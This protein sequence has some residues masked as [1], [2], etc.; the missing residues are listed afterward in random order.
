MYKRSK[1]NFNGIL[2]SG[3]LD[4]KSHQRPYAHFHFP[5]VYIVAKGEDKHRPNRPKNVGTAFLTGLDCD[6]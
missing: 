4:I 6:N 5:F 3:G 2:E 1:T